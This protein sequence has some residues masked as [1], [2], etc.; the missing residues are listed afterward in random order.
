[1]MENLIIART[2]FG[3]GGAFGLCTIIPNA[4]MSTCSISQPPHIA[5]RVM[6]MV[7]LTLA[8]SLLM[9]TSGFAG[10]IYPSYYALTAF[11]LG[12]TTQFLGLYFM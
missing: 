5:N 2:L 7:K 11:G 10:L 6:F 12:A 9:A 3:F 1:M 4:M 8:G